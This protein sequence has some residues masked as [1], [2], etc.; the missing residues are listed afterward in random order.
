[1]LDP[2]LSQVVGLVILHGVKPAKWSRTQ[3]LGA[4]GRE[5]VEVSVGQVELK[6]PEQCD[7]EAWVAQQNAGSWLP[8][9]FDVSYL[10]SNAVLLRAGTYGGSFMT[11]VSIGPFDASSMQRVQFSFGAQPTSFNGDGLQFGP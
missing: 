9:S 7:I 11:A 5:S 6:L 1:M 8:K 4:S 10:D 2:S 3:V